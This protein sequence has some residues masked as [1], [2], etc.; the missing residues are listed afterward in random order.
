MSVYP[1]LVQ[2]GTS[3]FDILF[4]TYCVGCKKLGSPLCSMCLGKLSKHTRE[5]P[6]WI[7][8][9]YDYRDPIVRTAIWNLK[10]KNTRGLAEIL[11]EEL[12]ERILADISE[13][14][15]WRGNGTLTLIPI[16][17]YRDR[18]QK[19]G[20]N[21]AELIARALTKKIPTLS[22]RTDLLYKVQATEHQS[23]IRNRYARMKNAEGMFAVHTQTMQ[24]MHGACGAMHLLLID[25]VTTTG[26]T[27]SSARKVL[28]AAGAK[29]VK[30]Y[31]VAH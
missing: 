6:L 29:S 25:D 3:L 16:P 26:A 14:R 27:L 10:F 17:L 31:T 30:A 22:V 28:L 19:R 5:L 1:T 13:G 23:H 24:K 21:Q 11:A 20:Y 15:A 12:A 18:K 8:S 9:V 7:E 2:I 4:P